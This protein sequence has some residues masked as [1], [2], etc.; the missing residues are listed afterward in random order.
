[1]K[2]NTKQKPNCRSEKFILTP[3]QGV[4]L[5]LAVMDELSKQRIAIRNKDFLSV[6]YIIGRTTALRHLRRILT[7]PG[8]Y[9]LKIDYF[10]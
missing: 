3:T 10:I 8:T 7:G 5:Y 2:Q 1:M 4:H 6:K 9:T